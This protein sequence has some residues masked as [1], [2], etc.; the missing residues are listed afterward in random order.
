MLLHWGL[1]RLYFS[2]SAKPGLS[3][4][5]Q[6][7]MNIN[8]KVIVELCNVF[9]SLIYKLYK[10]SH[11]FLILRRTPNFSS[12]R[13]TRNINPVPSE[14]YKQNCQL[15]LDS[16]EVFIP[17]SF[18]S[19]PSCNLGM[20]WGNGHWEFSWGRAH[21]TSWSFCTTRSIAKSILY[22]HKIYFCVWEEPLT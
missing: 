16:T 10:C 18:W 4:E 5:K 1:R 9:Q 3:L 12:V 22:M 21:K 15:P 7:S 8:R 11:L 6:Q 20:M 17:V 14:L 13:Y 2:S 19:Q